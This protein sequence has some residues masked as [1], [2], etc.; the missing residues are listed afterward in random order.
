MG[1]IR[2]RQGFRNHVLRFSIQESFHTLKRSLQM[3][4]DAR[5]NI[6]LSNIAVFLEYEWNTIPSKAVLLLQ[7]P[8]IIVK[9]P[10]HILGIVYFFSRHSFAKF[11][12][13]SLN[14]W[15]PCLS[16]F[17][18]LEYSCMQTGRASFYIFKTT[19]CFDDGPL[20]SSRACYSQGKWRNNQGGFH[21]WPSLE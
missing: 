4:N 21:I 12:R 8:V 15:S 18:S 17:N 14:L 11:S 1:C 10:D 13:L 7:N 5:A 20:T 3:R 9:S 2:G 6:N 19:F 16:Q